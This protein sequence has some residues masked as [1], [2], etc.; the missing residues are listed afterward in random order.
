MKRF[1]RILVAVVA[2]LVAVVA[3][4]CSNKSNSSKGGYTPKSLTIQF[5]PSQAATKL[6]ARAKP[7]EKMLSKR[8]GIPVHVSMSTDYNTVV[9][10]MKSKKVDVGFLPPDG[11]VLAH[12]QGAADLLLQ[13]ERYGVKQPGGKATNQ[14]VKSYRAEILVKKGSKIK[15]WKDLKGKSISVQNPTSTAGYVFP[16]AELKQKGLDVTK[17]CKL[18]TV[19]G[20]DQAVLNVLNGDTDAAFVFEDA[21]NIV[22][23]DNP[24]IMSQVVPIYFTRPIPNDTISVIPS[25]SKSFRKKLAKAFIAVGKSKEGKKVIESVYSHEGY[26][27]AK[28][29][30]FNIIRKYDKIVE[31]TKK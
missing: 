11:Y 21:R 29:S 15:N 27:Y 17:D 5:V 18:V 26:A 1:R 22:K 6:Q 4:A 20:H 19:T 10:A 23:K 24:K 13:A 16:V 2:L 9:E 8:L 25:M 14:L 30:D 7:L 3:T 31:S 12:K 28:D